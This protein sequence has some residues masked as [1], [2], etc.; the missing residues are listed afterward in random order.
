M[1]QDRE[2]RLAELQLKYQAD[3][4]KTDMKIQAEQ[5]APREVAQ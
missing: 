4:Q 2:I 5:M 3:L 1:A